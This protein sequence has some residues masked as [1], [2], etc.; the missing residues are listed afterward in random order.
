MAI[1]VPLRSVGGCGGGSVLTS[2]GT[3]PRS[4]SWLEARPRLEP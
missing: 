4:G 2:N 3:Q 1:R